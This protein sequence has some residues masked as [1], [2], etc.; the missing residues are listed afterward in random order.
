VKTLHAAL[1][2]TTIF[3]PVHSSTYGD[4]LLVATKQKFE[5]A[6]KNVAANFLLKGG[7]LSSYE[8][9]ITAFDTPS[10]NILTDDVA[11]TDI[12]LKAHYFMVRESIRSELAQRD[13]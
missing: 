3:N 7:T 1:F 12:L 6:N 4:L 10:S 9:P 11:N 2:E 13:L 8:L 5:T